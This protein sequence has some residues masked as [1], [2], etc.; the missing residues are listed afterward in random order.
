M[1][2]D[3]PSTP[4]LV[5]LKGISKRYGDLL[6]NDNVNLALKPGEVHALL[7]ENGAGKSTLVKI[8]YGVIEPTEGEILWEGR[9]VAITSP[10]EARALGI[11]MVFQHFSL[12]D[13]LTVAENIAVALSEDW[14]LRAVR[15]RIGEISTAYGLSL[16]PDRAVWTL[17]AGERQRIEI[18]RCLL[19]NPKLLIL[20]EPTSV[21]TPQEAENLF[22]TLDKLV[23]DGCA[24]LYISHKLEEVRRLCRAATIL[25]GGRVVG[26][27]DPRERSA[28]EIAAMMVG[29]EVG[30]VRAA[31]KP[32]GETEILAV[33]GLSVPATV[34][35]GQ[36]LKDIELIAHAGE[37]VGIAGVAG[38]GQSELFAA[39]SGEVAAVRDDAVVI[40]GKPAGLSGVDA[41][42]RTGAA[43]VPEERLGHAAA[44]THRLSDNVLISH[45]AGGEVS[46]SGFIVTKAAKRLAK[47]IIQ[48]FDVRTP[49]QEEAQARKLSG[50]NLQKFV[51][52]RE[53]IRRPKLLVVDQ[54]TWGVDA[55]AARLIRQALVDLAAEGGAVVL[56][57]QDLDELFEIAD[58]IAVIQHGHLSPLR[59]APEWTREAI[60]L[61]MLG[62]ARSSETA[63]AP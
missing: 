60:G 38:N 12:F 25:R 51:I 20:D 16:E 21:L 53:I 26:T 47:A 1:I 54:P 23:L 43:F 45:H 7:G 40:S 36:S 17:S 24:I 33:R 31:H 61:E 3:V 14:S 22:Q 2:S 32:P 9:P 4:A 50:G 29:A 28:R 19:Q 10:V 18:V 46:R 48:G 6:A 5:E 8:L 44:P 52:G 62:V 58:R 11:G 15:A 49:G 57:S 27:L 63:H 34:L 39:L 35:H 56:I 42:R 30:E 13:E 55:G 37:I 41:R 59:P